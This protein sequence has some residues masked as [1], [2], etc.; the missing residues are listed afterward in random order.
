MKNVIK[1]VLVFALLSL[2]T[3]C[4]EEDASGGACVG[5]WH[6]GLYTE[7]TCW[8][9]IESQS[10]CDSYAKSFGKTSGTFYP[11]DTCKDLNL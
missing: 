8:D 1:F 9:N 7:Y 5:A 2:L 11:G 10:E 3:G 6:N 4:S